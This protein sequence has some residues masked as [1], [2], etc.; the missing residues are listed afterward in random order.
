VVATRGHC[1]I[2]G[3]TQQASV[4][5]VMVSDGFMKDRVV[6]WCTETIFGCCS[7]KLF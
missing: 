3:T 6:Q 7:C 5:Y 2:I 4:K 1:S